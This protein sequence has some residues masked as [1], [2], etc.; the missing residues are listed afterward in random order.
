M[1]E[2]VENGDFVVTQENGENGE[3]VVTPVAR[4]A[5][6]RRSAEMLHR[7]LIQT[8]SRLCYDE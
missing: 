7:F 1:R 6:G 5:A 2:N 4:N 3:C 8:M